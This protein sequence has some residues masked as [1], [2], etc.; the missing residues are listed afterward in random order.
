MLSDIYV[1]LGTLGNIPNSVVLEQEVMVK[2]RVDASKAMNF[3]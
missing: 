2:E 3:N 1:H